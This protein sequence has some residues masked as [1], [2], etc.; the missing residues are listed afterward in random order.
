MCDALLVTL[1]TKTIKH[2]LQ[3]LFDHETKLKE[4]KNQ[5]YIYLYKSREKKA[6][7][8]LGLEKKKLLYSENCCLLFLVFKR[9]RY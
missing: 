8:R 4:K 9:E 6:S 3:V 5:Q 7:N 2:T 1:L